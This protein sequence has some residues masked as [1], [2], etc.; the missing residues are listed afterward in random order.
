MPNG[1]AEVTLADAWRSHQENV[2]G[3]LDESAAG[4]IE[5]LF[6]VKRFVEGE[7]KVF[8]SLW[9]LASRVGPLGATE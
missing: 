9:M 2:S 1:L 5:D 8:K 4:Q 3:L 6:S 7:V